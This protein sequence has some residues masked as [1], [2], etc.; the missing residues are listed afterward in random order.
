MIHLRRRTAIT[1]A[2][3]LLAGCTSSSDPTVTPSRTEPSP[4]PTETTR[5]SPTETADRSPTETTVPPSAITPY[6]SLSPDGRELFQT[7]LDHPVERASDTVPS[8]LWNATYVR[9]DGT[10]YELRKTSTDRSVAER[11]VSLYAAE[12]PTPEPDQTIEY[13]DLS[14][15]AQAAV[16]EALG[17]GSYTVRGETLPEP[18][19]DRAIQYLRYDGT[20]Y[21]IVRTTGDI[22]VWRLDV[23]EP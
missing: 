22:R 20:V 18:F 16:E 8:R 2:V 5:R 10:V 13:D 14:A 11:T 17:D 4:T 21:E 12:Q 3:A 19:G 9:Y 1:T 15:S 6:D 7:L 23:G